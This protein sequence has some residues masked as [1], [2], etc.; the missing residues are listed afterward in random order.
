MTDAEIGKFEDLYRLAQ[1]YRKG[2]WVFRGVS[3]TSF[4]LL[5]KIGRPGI[6]T[7][8]EKRIFQFF[9]REATAYVS[10]MPKSE[11]EMLAIA[12]HHGLPTRLLDWT[13]NPLV[14]AYFACREFQ[15]EDGAIYVLR[16]PKVLKEELVSPFEIDDVLRYRP[17]HITRRIS[18][19]RGLFTV[20]PNPSEPLYVG[21]TDSLKVRRAFIRKEYKNKLL[22]NL[23]R[24]DINRRSLFPDLDGLAWHLTWMFSEQDPSEEAHAPGT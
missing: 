4:E 13:E 17:R 20:H 18:A 19:Q 21:D 24:F 3:R 2:R 5:P 12:Q 1:S 8:N 16:T 15:D 9:I 14:A 10:Q 6:E 23:S 11:W 7:E 22:W